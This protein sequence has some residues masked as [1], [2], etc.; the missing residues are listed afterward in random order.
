MEYKT[1]DTSYDIISPGTAGV[2]QRIASKYEASKGKESEETSKLFTLM[3]N[4]I[5][6]CSQNQY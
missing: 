6:A 4:D 3:Q 1:K 2:A 5:M